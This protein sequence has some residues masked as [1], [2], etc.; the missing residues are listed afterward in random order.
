ML[1]RQRHGL[2][3]DDCLKLDIVEIVWFQSSMPVLF[4][5]ICKSLIKF[6]NERIEHPA[7]PKPHQSQIY[8]KRFEH[9]KSRYRSSVFGDFVTYYKL[10]WGTFCDSYRLSA[11]RTLYTWHK[12]VQ[13][14]GIYP[15]HHI[16]RCLG[17]FDLTPFNFF[18]VINVLFWYIPGYFTNPH[19][20]EPP[21]RRGCIWPSNI[22]K[23]ISGE[24]SS[25]D[26][27]SSICKIA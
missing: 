1:S 9:Y 18:K 21:V 27:R 22:L 11:A 5:A 8:I 25:I 12:C 4:E 6:F 14:E 20:S 17:G 23:K 19:T 13:M 15:S 10:F 7:F 3:T 16:M 24:C 2:S 26:H